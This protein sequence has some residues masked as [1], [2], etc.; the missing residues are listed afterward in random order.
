M[1]EESFVSV[2]FNL[3]P[4]PRKFGLTDW[5]D[6]IIVESPK[7]GSLSL[8]PAEDMEDSVDVDAE[9]VRAL[10]RDLYTRFAQVADI[11]EKLTR[12]GWGARLCTNNIR[13]DHPYATSEAEA[14]EDLRELGI[15]PEDLDIEVIEMNDQ[16]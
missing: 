11:V 16:E 9:D 4:M 8:K 13:L 10:G 12:A 3:F 1:P 15:D 5:W 14:V 2:S 6:P 7:F